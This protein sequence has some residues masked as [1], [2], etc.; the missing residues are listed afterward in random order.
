MLLWSKTFF[1]IRSITNSRFSISKFALYTRFGISK[2]FYIRISIFNIRIHTD[3]LF[4]HVMVK[5]GLWY[6]ERNR[7][8]GSQTCPIQK[9][10]VLAFQPIIIW[11]TEVNQLE[12]PWPIPRNSVESD[13]GCTSRIYFENAG[14]NKTLTLYNVTRT[15]QK[16]CWRNKECDCRKTNGYKLSLWVFPN[17]YRCYSDILLKNTYTS[18]ILLIKLF[19]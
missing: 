14:D 1:G 12:L 7:I 5:N 11:V 19:G 3:F 9:D 13:Q 8:S 6:Y 15:S 2:Y 17:E 4:I 10:R 16:P 18:F